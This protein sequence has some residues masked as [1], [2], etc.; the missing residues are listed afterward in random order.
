MIDMRYKPRHLPQISMPYDA[1]MEELDKMGID[2]EL[3][4]I[5][6]DDLNPM[7]GIVFSDEVG[8]FNPNEMN[9]IWISKD[10]DV[11]DG[12]HRFVAGLKSQTPIIGVRIGLNGRDAA[13]ELNKIQDIHEYEQQRQMEEVVTQNA[14]NLHNEP[15]NGISNNEFLASLEETEVPEGNACIIMAYRQKPIMENS[16]IGNFFMLE[17]IEGY[18]KYEIE[19]DNLLDTNDL[20]IHFY[21]QHPVDAL[22]KAW[23]PNID[24]ENMS[25]PYTHSPQE[26]KNKAIVDRAKKMGFDGIKYGDS[27]IQGLK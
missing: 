19:F 7:Q 9:P 5:S 4:E 17:P 6:P 26:L 25:E 11:I 22:A 10:N 3:I 18:D 2:C 24:F 27:I 20:G 1:V 23:F 8:T 15:E 16:A 14:I 12:H 21:E 13:R